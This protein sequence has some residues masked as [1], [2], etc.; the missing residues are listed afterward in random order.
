MNIFVINL[1]RS[2]DRLASMSAQFDALKMSWERFPGKDGR[3][4]PPEE[5]SQYSEKEALQLIG[6]PMTRGQIGALLSHINV[7][8]RIVEDKLPYA[9]VLEDDVI[10][11]ANLNDILQEPW[12]TSG[13][14][15][16]VNLSYEYLSIRRM[17]RWIEVT[18]SV[19]KRRPY[20]AF[21]ALIKFPYMCF[22]MMFESARQYFYTKKDRTGIVS[23]FRPIYPACAYLLSNTGARK[24]LSI[25]Y[26]LRC[27]ADTLYNQAR[28]KAG[29]RFFGYCPAA[30]IT[31]TS[32]PSIS[33]TTL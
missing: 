27:P 2:A 29:L 12:I 11:P 31:A 7:C 16:Y 1:E 19:I 28:I 14:W 30:P 25:A 23:Y 24:V 13:T 21:Y 6:E 15:D 18:W 32:A 33:L 17:T 26:P 22:M 8:K 5:L 3:E 9:L 10:L 4:L 20:Y